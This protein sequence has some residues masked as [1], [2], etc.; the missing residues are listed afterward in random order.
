MLRVGDLSINLF[1]AVLFLIVLLAVLALLYGFAAAV[2]Q[3]A[4]EKAMSIKARIE[5]NGKMEE[6]AEIV[7]DDKQPDPEVQEPDFFANLEAEM[8]QEAKFNAELHGRLS[9]KDLLNGT[10]FTKQYEIDA[11]KDELQRIIESGGDVK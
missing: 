9:D 3:A 11:V 10:G 6:E 1:A 2:F 4:K 5:N 8:G 7:S